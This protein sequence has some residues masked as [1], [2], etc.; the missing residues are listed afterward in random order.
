MR[1]SQFDE[2]CGLRQ[3]AVSCAICG[4]SDRTLKRTGSVSVRKFSRSVLFGE[5]IS[6]NCG[7]YSRKTANYALFDHKTN[8]DILKELWN[9]FW[10]KST[11][12]TVNWH[13][14]VEWA[15]SGSC[16]LL[17]NI[18]RRARERGRSL[19]R[20]L[21]CCI[22]PGTGHQKKVLMFLI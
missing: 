22:Q 9:T 19:K 21:D 5:T 14:F 12:I 16:M 6:I 17:W 11:A 20:L 1:E 4:H 15:E 13:M 18:N 8:R 2:L 10:D 3:T 7:N